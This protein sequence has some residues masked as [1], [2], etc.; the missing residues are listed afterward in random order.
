MLTP[1][2]EFI[3]VVDRSPELWR[4]LDIRVL[5]ARL[6]DGWHN[7]LSRCYLDAREPDDVIRLPD[8]PVTE[9]LGCWQDVVRCS[10]LRRVLESVE[11]GDLVIGAERVKYIAV[12][13]HPS[14]Q[15]YSFIRPGL[16]D[17]SERLHSSY[18]YWSAHSVRAVGNPLWDLVQNI[19]GG[20]GAL[21][22]EL[23]THPEPFDGLS[24]AAQFALGSPDPLS[25]DR[26]TVFEVFAPLESLFIV[27]RCFLRGGELG[28]AIRAGSEAARR[29]VELG[30][31][32]LGPDPVPRRTSLDLSAIEWEP[33][34]PYWIAESSIRL[35]CVQFATLILRSP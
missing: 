18:R 10:E 20:R 19:S 25:D 15:R 29:A 26:A 2:S 27:D 17:Q 13:A 21:D 32:A 31:F 23:R 9:H 3:A 30:V 28:F 11:Q 4:S 34:G 14:D 6:E 8:L 5:A 33:D 1:V 16:I 12:M 7:L 22:N 35:E 24:G